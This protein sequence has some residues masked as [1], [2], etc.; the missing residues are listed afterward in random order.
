VWWKPQGRDIPAG[1]GTGCTREVTR[2][3]RSKFGPDLGRD[4][5]QHQRRPDGAHPPADAGHGCATC[6][7][8]P[9]GTAGLARRNE[10]YPV[11]SYPL[12]VQTAYTYHFC[13]RPLPADSGGRTG[14]PSTTRRVIERLLGGQIQPTDG[15]GHPEL[16]G[17]HPGGQGRGPPYGYRWAQAP[18]AP[19]PGS[20]GTGPEEPRPRPR[21]RGE[22]GGADPGTC[23][24]RTARAGQRRWFED[25]FVTPG[26]WS[27][28]NTDTVDQAAR[29]VAAQVVG[30]AGAPAG[31]PGLVVRHDGQVLS[32][33]MLP[34]PSPGIFRAGRRGTSAGPEGQPMRQGPWDRLLRIVRPTWTAI[35][36]AIVDGQPGPGGHRRGPGGPTPGSGG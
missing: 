23:R 30:Q 21:D 27:C 34:W 28:G 32:A 33:A 7:H 13:S 18:Y 1:A 8:L 35:V 2:S 36:A 29:K 11:R 19:A 10:K 14:T 22:A 15:R 12:E 4:H 16:D 9:V 31:P 20:P 5:R 17:P 24:S 26:S 25:D 3:G 6:C